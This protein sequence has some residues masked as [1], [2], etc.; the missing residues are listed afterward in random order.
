MSIEDEMKLRFVDQESQIGLHTDFVLVRNTET[1]ECGQASCLHVLF[2]GIDCTIS[3]QHVLRPKAEYYTGARRLPVD[4]ITKN[5]EEKP[6]VPSLRL[7]AES[8]K[9]DLALFDH[10]G[11][12]LESIPKRSYALGEGAVTF[13]RTL[14]NKGTVSFIYGTP[15]FATRGTQYPDGMVYVNTPIYRACGPIVS[16]EADRITA[17]FAEAILFELNTKDAQQLEGFRISGGA[18]DLG[19]MSGSGLWIHDRLRFRLA[20]VLRGPEAGSDMTHSHII[21]FT[22]VWSLEEWMKSVII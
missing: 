21:E 10:P 6:G 17:D 20:G 18:R 22:P 16:V 2:E 1:G 15:G 19:G 9:L 13:E 11:L 5:D 7:L 12:D 14:R 8:A 3:C 4:C